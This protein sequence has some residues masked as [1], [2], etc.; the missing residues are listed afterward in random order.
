MKSFWHT[1]NNE[2]ISE[3]HRLVGTVGLNNACTNI[4]TENAMTDGQSDFSV[5]IFGFG[6]RVRSVPSVK[7]MKLSGLSCVVCAAYVRAV[8]RTALPLGSP[9]EC[10]LFIGFYTTFY[11]HRS[12]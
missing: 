6:G 11:D 5:T 12:Q 9:Q 7:Q 1:S 2:H 8:I 3:S 4:Y 10:G